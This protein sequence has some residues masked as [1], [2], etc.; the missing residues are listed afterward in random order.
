MQ[1]SRHRREAIGALMQR[2][3]TDVA[4]DNCC[5]GDGGVVAEASDRHR[6]QGCT[7]AAERGC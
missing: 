1:R 6:S 4:G 2:S 3:S 5:K 7:R